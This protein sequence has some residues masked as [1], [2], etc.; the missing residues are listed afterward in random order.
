M[1]DW[2]PPWSQYGLIQEDL[3][4]DAWKILVACLMLNCT[5]RK[6]VDGVI[7]KFFDACPTPEV[8]AAADPAALEDILRPLGMQHKRARTLVRFSR[9]YL[10]DWSDVGELH[11]VGK[12][13][14]DA[15]WIFVLGR[16]TEVEPKDHALTA[17]WLWLHN[18][19][20]ICDQP[21]A[22]WRGRKVM[23]SLHGFIEGIVSEIGRSLASGYHDV[24][25]D[26]HVESAVS[27]MTDG[28]M[29][30]DVTV[31][32]EHHVAIRDTR[33]DLLRDLE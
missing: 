15:Y 32:G 29:R 33:F 14:R 2:R 22:S 10:G 27:T 4:P 9:E 25:F 1:S 30:L 23:N 16:W 8:C 19:Y 28:V 26:A 12:Y 21:L 7:W 17:Y 13:A 31:A 11:G 24:R 6:Q 3:W 18:T 20:E 5:T